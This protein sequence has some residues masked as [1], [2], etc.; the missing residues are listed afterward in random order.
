MHPVF[1]AN[2]PIS[3]Y[4]LCYFPLALVVGGLLFA[5][6]SADRDANRPYRRFAVA[7]SDMD[8]NEAPGTR[9]SQAEVLVNQV[10]AELGPEAAQEAL[11][12]IPEAQVEQLLQGDSVPQSGNT[13]VVPNDENPP[14]EQV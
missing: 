4:I 8:V 12:T 10:T 3:A 14:P 1:L 9:L 13:P 7:P 11:G 2:L 6:L 5:F